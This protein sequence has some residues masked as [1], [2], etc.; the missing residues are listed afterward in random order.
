VVRLEGHS[1]KAFLAWAA[2]LQRNEKRIDKGGIVPWT[3]VDVTADAMGEK[4]ILSAEASET[5]HC[6]A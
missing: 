1:G 4:L 6:R 3:L 2:M 5:S